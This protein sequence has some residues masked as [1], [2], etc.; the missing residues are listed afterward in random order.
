MPSKVKPVPDGYRTVTPYLYVRGA[1]KALEFYKKAFAAVE[2]V[3]MP[4]PGDSIM[5]ASRTPWKAAP[6]VP[7]PRLVTW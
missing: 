3:R 7:R 5:H 1:A 2:K 4:G 6:G